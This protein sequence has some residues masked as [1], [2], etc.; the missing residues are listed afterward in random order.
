MAL[1]Q[2]FLE[3]VYRMKDDVAS[4]QKMESKM[5]I[6]SSVVQ[7][8]SKV[9]IVI[10]QTAQAVFLNFFLCVLKKK[11]MEMY[12]VIGKKFIFFWV[13]LND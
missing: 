7:K 4:I 13:V 5:K 6:K 10:F 3:Y 1:S 8:I 12:I 11:N 2:E 9:L